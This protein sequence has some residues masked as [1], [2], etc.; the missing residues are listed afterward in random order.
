MNTDH[1]QQTVQAFQDH[2][3]K[4]MH[5][6]EALAVMYW[7][8]RT[9]APKKGAEQRSKA[10]GTL[11]SEVFA[12]QTSDEMM[13]FL[14][15]LQ[16]PEAQKQLDPITK[17][18]LVKVNKDFEK[19]RKIPK[20]TYHDY[21][22]L[23]ST[24]ESVWETAKA[25]RDF[26]KFQPYL[27]KIVQYNI[28][29]AERWGYAAN[30]YDA[31]L[32]SYEPG[33]PVGQIDPVF[34]ELR[35]HIVD[36]LKDVQASPHQPDTSFIQQRFP[37]RDQQAFGLSLLEAIGF[38]F[39]AGRLDV[40]VH[41]FCTALNPGDVR[42]TTKYDERDFRT[43]LFGTIHEGGHALYEQNISEQ[44]VGTPLHTG[45]SMGMHESQSLFWE[46]F[47]GR[48]YEFWSQHYRQLVKQFPE[49][50]GDV[51]LDTF[52]QGIN[53][54]VPSFIRIEADELTYTLHIMIRYEIEKGLI[55]EQLRVSDLPDIWNAKM[56]E[57]LGIVPPDDGKGVL[58]DV[59]WSGGAFGYF[60]SYAL[61][62]IYAAQFRTALIRDIPDVH[63]HIAQGHFKP[64]KD[65]LTEH[66][67]QHGSMYDPRDLLNR[68]TGQDLDASHLVTYLQDKYK[69]VYKLR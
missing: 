10:I 62:Y 41:P 18:V 19:F 39:D 66:I 24:A 27:E 2:L 68:V 22:V 6:E 32:D 40:T 29:F 51:D 60:P 7:D 20:D 3:Q 8:L 35:R 33:V 42:V 9:G 57:Y 50:L 65:W 54:A 16:Q 5:Y 12:L 48:S 61:G 23:T 14:D 1:V 47:V 67:H 17:R 21:V 52:Y 15:T 69:D 11:S 26:K 49:Q 38:D 36:L 46:N 37:Q 55:N 63:H 31:L 58:Q 53:V 56:D 43:S 13:R 59:H 4:I 28:E 64:I 25:E 34:A 45:T 44:L 30:R